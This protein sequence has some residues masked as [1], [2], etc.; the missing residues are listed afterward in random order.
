MATNFKRMKIDRSL[1]FE[2]ELL[3]VV[4]ERRDNSATQRLCHYL[5]F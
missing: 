1:K 5:Y 3:G 2:V 4:R